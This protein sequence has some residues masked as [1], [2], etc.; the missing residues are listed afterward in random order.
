MARGATPPNAG[1]LSAESAILVDAYT[2]EVLF[3]KNADARRPVA[4]TQ[5]L[6]TA[7]L[8]VE[9][10]RLFSE[11]GVEQVDANAEPTRVGIKAG[12]RYVLEGLVRAL[13]VKSGNDLA[14]CIGRNLS[15]SEEAFAQLM[16]LRARHLGMNDSLFKTASGLPMTGQH[17]TARD[18][19][20]AAR[21][22]YALAEVR[23]MI[24]TR[25][26]KFEFNDGRTR[27]LYNTNKLLGRLP[28]CDGMKTGYTRRAGRCL[29]ASAN[30]GAR[31]VISVCLKSTPERVWGDSRQ[32]LEYG[33]AIPPYLGY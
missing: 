27:N 11:V 23:E 22:A 6:I 33:L 19:A 32:L 10:G 18:M 21:A 30:R 14:R 28:G 5:K 9:S 1:A 25:Q 17:S 8:A 3:E 13:L 4:S 2:G 15:G 31:A 7:L 26:F 20:K 24:T 29:V 12:E 16:T